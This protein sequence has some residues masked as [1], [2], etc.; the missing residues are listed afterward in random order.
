MSSSSL[1]D[2]DKPVTTISGSSELNGIMAQNRGK[3]PDRKSLL[4]AFSLKTFSLR[5][6]KSM[7]VL[8]WVGQ[9]WVQL[10]VRSTLFLQ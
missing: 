5:A 9:D 2:D 10:L 3:L 7:S 8:R 1:N 6:S 4:A